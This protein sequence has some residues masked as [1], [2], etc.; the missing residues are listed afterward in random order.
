MNQELVSLDRLA[1]RINEQQARIEQAWGMTLELAKEAGEMLIEAKRVVGHGNWLP[2]IEASCHVSASMAEK[3]MKVAK[4]WDALTAGNPEH[5]PNLSIRDAVKLLAKPRQPKA[6][7]PPTIDAEFT[8]VAE[9]PLAPTNQ[10][11]ADPVET[12]MDS[13]E[14]EFMGIPFSGRE[15]M[16]ESAIERLFGFKDRH[17]ASTTTLARLRESFP[18]I[19]HRDLRQEVAGFIGQ[20]RYARIQ[21]NDQGQEAIRTEWAE[22]FIRAQEQHGWQTG[23]PLVPW[24]NLIITITTA[25]SQI[26]P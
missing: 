26:L 18:G 14:A 21:R 25:K 23:K 17:C 9:A 15:A 13:L 8:E 1:I 12:L 4:G 3:Y 20:W 5:V 24:G 10:P 7:L 6:E 22:E 16:V 2:W 19:G 11:P